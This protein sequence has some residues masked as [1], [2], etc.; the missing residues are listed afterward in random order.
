MYIKY[1]QICIS[2]KDFLKKIFFH[3]KISN[4]ILSVPQK[5]D[6]LQSLEH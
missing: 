5:I 4:F 1:K 3:Q 6:L 2:Q